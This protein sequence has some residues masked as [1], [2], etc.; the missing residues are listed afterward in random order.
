MKRCIWEREYCEAERGECCSLEA[1][2]DV[3]DTLRER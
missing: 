3:S 1:L 2:R